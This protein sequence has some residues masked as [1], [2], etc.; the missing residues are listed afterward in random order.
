MP[1]EFGELNQIVSYIKGAVNQCVPFLGA[2]VNV[3]SEDPAYSGLPLGGH[4]ANLFLAEPYFT[5]VGKESDRGNLAKVS[6]QYEMRRTRSDLT[7]WLKRQIPDDD[8][9][10]S[11]LLRVLATLNF[12][13]IVTTNYDR[14]M[15][16]ALRQTGKKEGIDFLTIVQP[17]TGWDL[18]AEPTLFERF[19]D[20][21]A[22][23]G[24][25]IYKIHG[26]FVG[27]AT[28]REDN[29]VTE[30]KPSPIVIT[31]EDYIAFMTIMGTASPERIGIPEFLRSRML[32][33]ML[34]FLGYGLEDWDIRGLY[35][36]L[37]HD[38]PPYQRRD[39]FAIQHDASNLWQNF[40]NKRNV[41]VRNYDLYRFAAELYEACCQ[42]P[43][44][45]TPPDAAS[46][47]DHLKSGQQ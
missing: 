34:L 19:A 10:P 22:F 6:Q 40:W 14:M 38:I 47:L 46:Q 25:I 36:G 24:T 5:F 16:R 21:A 27:T 28:R 17:P 1:F 23:S 8:H 37:I 35:N 33:S 7:N 9:E 42:T 11:P 39:S 43:L 13:L 45:R 29:W 31:E 18:L 3:T 41:L 15:E 20:W 44:K 2:G 4:L 32:N 26:S 30:I 12:R